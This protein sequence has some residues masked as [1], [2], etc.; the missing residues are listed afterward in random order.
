MNRRT[1][2]EGGRYEAKGGWQK[3]SLFAGVRLSH[4]DYRASTSFRNVF[5]A[6]GQLSGSF[7]M[8]HTHLDLGAGLQLNAGEGAIVTPSLGVYG[9]SL[10]QDGSSASNAVLVADVP[11]YR[12]SYQGWRAGVQLKAS[13]WLSWTNDIKVRPQLGLSLYRTRTG[14]PGSLAMNQRDRLGVLNFTRSLPVRG[15]PHTVN[16]LKAGISLKK[17][18]G[19][20]MK[21]DYVGYEADGKVQHGVLARMRVGF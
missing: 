8:V 10:S 17:Q 11:G 1:S 13:D 6:G 18:D 16:A 3:D 21:L 20:S 5:E 9:G 4:G 12:Q 14:G 2:F 19:L 15:L 7:E